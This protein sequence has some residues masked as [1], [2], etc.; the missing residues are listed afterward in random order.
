MFVISLFRKPMLIVVLLLHAMSRNH[1]TCQV[2]RIMWI[3]GIRVCLLS[4]VLEIRLG[5]VA[6]LLL[7]NWVLCQGLLGVFIC[8]ISFLCFVFGWAVIFK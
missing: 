7:I 2:F 1:D 5:R 6:K 3:S 4:A 8:K